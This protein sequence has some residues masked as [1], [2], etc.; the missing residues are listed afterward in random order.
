[1]GHASIDNKTP[2][3]FAAL[4]LTNEDGRPI[5]VTVVRATFSIRRGGLA[6]A[7]EQSPVPLGGE[8]WY[9]DADVSSWKHEPE[10]AFVKPSTD[11]VVLGSAY[12]VR[13]GTEVEV[14][15]QVGTT[16]RAARVIGD[17]VWVQGGITKPQP[18]ERIPL[19]WERAFG[20]WDRTT[21]SPERPEFEQ[22]NPVGTGFR[23]K[24]GVFE[25]GIRLPNIENPSELLT[26]YGQVV[27]PIGFG[28]TSSNWQPR[29]GL[30]GTYDANWM[31][32]RMPLVPAD[33]DRRFFNAA[34]PG[35]V[36]P[37]Y[38]RGDESVALVGMS[39]LGNVSFRLPGI[40][41][42]ICRI[43]LGRKQ[44]DVVLETVLDTVV[45]DMEDDRVFLTYRAH[46]PLRDG[47]HDVKSI[48]ISAD[49]LHSTKI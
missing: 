18:F 37:R 1:M 40:A 34:A 21:G 30:G 6:L 10:I 8:V 48:A 29:A 4:H 38:L 46:A 41:R 47:P 36:A 22:R 33:F 5:V 19:V 16:M 42:P 2:Y 44:E 45:I 43:S 13:G 9:P 11:I 15:A 32:D 25:S 27:A 14:A 17:R 20:G 39:P 26:S 35:L 12:S 49:G 28:F 24:S 7:E 31:R 23:S 3:E